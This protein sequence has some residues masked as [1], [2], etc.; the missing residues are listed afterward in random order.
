MARGLSFL[1]RLDVL[2]G[3]KAGAEEIAARQSQRLQRTIR[4]AY[5]RVPYYR[6]LFDQAGVSP[7]RIRT[8]EDLRLLPVT[9][10]REFQALPMEQRLA[11]GVD[12]GSLIEFTTSG[13]TGRP[14]QM[15]ETAWD[16]DVNDMLALRLYRFHGMKPWHRKLGLRSRGEVPVDDS[17]HAKL[18]LFRRG[19][20]STRWTPDRWVETLRSFRPDFI[21]GYSLTLGVIARLLV[22]R[23]ITDVRPVC[24]LTSSNVLDAAT[25][26]DIRKGFACPVYD[27]YAS[28]EGGIMAWECGRCPGY[29]INA[30]WV[31]IEILRGGRPALPG[32][33]G[34]V[35]LTSLHAGGTPFIRYQIGDVAVRN[36]KKPVCGCALPLLGDVFGRQGDLVVAPDGRTMSPHNFL[37]LMDGISGVERWRLVQEA[38]DRFRVEIVPRPDFG[39]AS[40]AAIRDGLVEILEQNVAVN[41]VRLEKPPWAEDS[42]FRPIVS[43]VAPS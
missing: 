25:R 9:T 36:T 23:G 22:E 3:T 14:L 41:I 17:L 43:E 42:K 6:R 24:V 35:V 2:R 8:A 34:D 4:H 37:S 5:D 38:R 15:R 31:V 12:T 32:E 11:A 20:M 27:V 10:R 1:E 29:H 28:W 40:E 30:D 7:D 39:T 19:W 26:E 33:A 21:L 16:Q 13:T 18:G